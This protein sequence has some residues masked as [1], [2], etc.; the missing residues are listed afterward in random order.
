MTARGG[1]LHGALRHFLTLYVG[2]IK[3]GGYPRAVKR[4]RVARSRLYRSHAV[5]MVHKLAHRAHA[6]DPYAVHRSR[7]ARI[8]G[9][10]IHVAHTRLFCL[11]AHTQRAAHRADITGERQLARKYRTLKRHRAFYHARA[12]QNAH[13]NGKVKRRALLAAV[14]RRKIDRQSKL[15]K[16]EAAVEAGC[17]HTLL[18]LLDRGVGK[19]H[20]LKIGQHRRAV[21]LHGDNKAVDPRK[22]RAVYL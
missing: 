4:V 14:G 20:K 8:G 19:P 11:G 5:E 17:A 15:R 18:R 12:A 1:Y 13:K 2:K 21:H 7:L 16:A 3:P 9:G 22:P 10:N 6:Y